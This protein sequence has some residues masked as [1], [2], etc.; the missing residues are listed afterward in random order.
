MAKFGE[1]SE[2]TPLIYQIILVVLVLVLIFIMLKSFVF[3]K[4]NTEIAMLDKKIADLQLKVNQAQAYQQ[5]RAVYQQMYRSLLADLETK[6]KILPKGKETDQLVRRLENIATQSEDIDIKVFRPR[7]PINHDFY[8]EWPIDIKC[9]AGYNSMGQFFEKIANFRRIFNITTMKLD[10]LK[11]GDPNKP[12]L[13]AAFTAS[14]FVYIGDESE[15]I[16]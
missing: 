7:S 3:D 6:K 5:K 12:T 10:S 1:K 2:G 11:S 9:V 13:K 14:T 8:F 15:K 4:M 16:K